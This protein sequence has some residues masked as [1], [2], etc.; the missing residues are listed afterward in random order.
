M[1]VGL[2][3][4]RHPTHLV[5]PPDPECPAS[6]HLVM[7]VVLLH[8]VRLQCMELMGEE[9]PETRHPLRVLDPIAR[10]HPTHSV[11]ELVR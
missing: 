10:R 6:R 8:R 3:L 4:R 1:Q 7:G 9:C 2:V 5:R 11:R